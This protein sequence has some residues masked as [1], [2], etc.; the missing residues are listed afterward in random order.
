MQVAIVTTDLLANSVMITSRQEARKDKNLAL[1]RHLR[2]KRRQ[3]DPALALVEGSHTDLALALVEG[4]DDLTLGEGREAKADL[5]PV[6][7][8][9]GDAHSIMFNNL[10][11]IHLV[12]LNP[13]LLTRILRSMSDLTRISIKSYYELSML[14]KLLLQTG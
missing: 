3:N 10:H 7:A 8:E 5:D 12:I 11:A 9:R 6:L 14:I 13:P 4:T 2:N 1:H